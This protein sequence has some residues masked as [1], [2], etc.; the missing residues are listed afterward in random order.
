VDGGS[1]EPNREVDELRWV[2]LTEAHDL[3]THDRDRE[4]LGRL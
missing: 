1:F 4:L 2:A 3:L